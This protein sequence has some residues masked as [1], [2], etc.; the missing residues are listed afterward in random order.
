ML[1]VLMDGVLMEYR[2]SLASTSATVYMHMAVSKPSRLYVVNDIP[3]CTLQRQRARPALRLLAKA[4]PL[5]GKSS[6][7]PVN[8]HPLASSASSPVFHKNVH[9]LKRVMN[10]DGPYSRPRAASTGMC[11]TYEQPHRSTRLILQYVFL[12]VYRRTAVL[13]TRHPAPRGPW[14]PHIF[15][16]ACA[17]VLSRQVI[18]Y[19]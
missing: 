10:A 1:S 8:M 3:M 5:S 2:I 15:L 9:P 17:G 18:W 16:A 7:S 11:R 13:S 6:P 4:A 14:Q 12:I 19:T